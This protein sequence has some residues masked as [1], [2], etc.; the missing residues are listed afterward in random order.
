MRTIVPLKTPAA[1]CLPLVPEE[2]HCLLE[3]KPP[4]DLPKQ[5]IIIGL[6]LLEEGKPVGIAVASA[7]P[8]SERSIIH[9]LSSP[10]LLPSM[11]D[12][13]KKINKPHMWLI[14]EER[15]PFREALTPLGWKGPQLYKSTYYFDALAFHPPWLERSYPTSQKYQLFPWGSLRKEEKERIEYYT[16]QGR[17][18]S[19]MYPWRYDI[20][21]TTS[22]GL[23]YEGEVVGWSI[24]QRVKPDV[25][26]YA[27]LYVEREHRHRGEIIK[28]LMESMRAQQRAEIPDAEFFVMPMIAP[29]KWGDFIKKRLAP[30][31]YRIKRELLYWKP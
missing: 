2:F 19:E 20:D 25:L 5:T 31:A 7:D 9:V 29:A 1:E 6:V 11:E 23:R 28:L 30:L 26:Q 4:K 14:V 16:A 13:L 21:L 24:T 3:G 10:E 27:A 18:L 17:Y 22:F 15:V 8:H 12:A